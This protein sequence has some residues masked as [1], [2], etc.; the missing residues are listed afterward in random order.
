MYSNI[1]LKACDDGKV[2][3]VRNKQGEIIGVE[4]KHYDAEILENVGN[5]NADMW[6]VLN[7]TMGESDEPV[8]DWFLIYRMA[9]LIE[10]GVL[11][12][13]GDFEK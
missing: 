1:F 4:E 6:E 10:E 5:N 11:D 9:L 12:S 3:H 7:K 13:V 2:L 8:S